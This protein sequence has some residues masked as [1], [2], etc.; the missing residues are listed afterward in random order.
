MHAVRRGMS[1]IGLQQHL[2]RHHGSGAHVKHE[3]MG[4]SRQRERERI[5]AEEPLL[6]ARRHHE[7]CRA[8]RVNTDKPGAGDP[9]QI[10]GVAPAEPAVVRADQG[11]AVRGRLFDCDFGTAIHHDVTDMIAA[12]DPSGHR[13]LVD[14][15]N[16]GARA[17]DLGTVAIAR[18][19]GKPAKR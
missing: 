16:R 19:R 10:V 11:D 8:H 14:D 18:M 15:G 2:A 3:G 6:R 4:V 13:R 9:F 12:I 17:P 7:W 5:G 1:Q